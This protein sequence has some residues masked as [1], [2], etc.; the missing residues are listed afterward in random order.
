MLQQSLKT[1]DVMSQQ[2]QY[3][4]RV[5]AKS[6]LVKYGADMTRVRI[7]C[8]PTNVYLDGQLMPDGPGKFTPTKIVAL[9]KELQQRV[10]GVAVNCNFDNW[11]VE[12]TFSGFNVNSK[13]MKIS[14]TSGGAGDN[15]HISEDDLMRDV[16]KDMDRKKS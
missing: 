14:Y 16:L 7:T 4:N 6:V 15:F 12:R 11:S 2:K 3:I 8:T 1:G 5:T 13:R 10:H 9:L